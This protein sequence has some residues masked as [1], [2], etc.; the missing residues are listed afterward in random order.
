MIKFAESGR[1]EN[2]K[3]LERGVYKENQEKNYP[4]Q[5]HIPDC[6]EGYMG[7]GLENYT[8]SLGDVYECINNKCQWS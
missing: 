7:C 2:P 1:D 8:D 3:G 5:G 6:S 4:S